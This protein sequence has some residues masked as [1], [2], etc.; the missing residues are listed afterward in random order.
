MFDDFEGKWAYASSPLVDDPAVEKG[1]LDMLLEETGESYDDL[2]SGSS[3]DII[4]FKTVDGINKLI[5]T[6]NGTVMNYFRECSVSGFTPNK[7]RWYFYNDSGSV[8]DMGREY[9]VT[10][11][12]LSKANVT[13]SSTV[14]DEKEAV[15]LMI[16][17]K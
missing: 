7:Y 11:L 16:H 5:P 6:G 9:N 4:E 14:I 3:S 17:E 13:Y 15:A 8:G 2:P 1:E 12:T 10:T